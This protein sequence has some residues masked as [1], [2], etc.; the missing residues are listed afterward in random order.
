MWKVGKKTMQN[1]K[2]NKLM[3]KAGKFISLGKFKLALEQYLEIHALETEDPTV[4]NMIADIY[5][6]MGQKQEALAWYQTLA[7]LFAEQ[8]KPTQAAAI[9]KKVLQLNP[10]N[11]EITVC[12]AQLYERT[13]QS[14]NAKHQYK[15]IVNQ[16]VAN[17]NYDQAIEICKKVCQ[18]DPN[19]PEEKLNLAKTLESAGRLSE[20]VR[21]YLA[22]SN[23][24]SNSKNRKRRP[25]SSKTFSG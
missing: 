9:Y 11:P 19:S 22:V 8:N 13:G 17:G 1:P 21:T 14:A 7:E 12:L 6:R 18:L 5:L 16:Q 25:Q 3:E 23:S 24:W 4:M 2:T 15:I 10:S 20:A